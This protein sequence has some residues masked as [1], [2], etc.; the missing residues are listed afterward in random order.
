M[1][2]LLF[3]LI[4]VCEEKYVFFF[5]L[6]KEQNPGQ[7]QTSLHPCHYLL[8]NQNYI[9]NSSIGLKSTDPYLQANL[10]SP[11]AS[12]MQPHESKSF[13]HVNGLIQPALP[14]RSTDI[15]QHFPTLDSRKH[16]TRN[17]QAAPFREN[18]LLFY[19]NSQPRSV[20]QEEGGIRVRASDGC[21][22]AKQNTYF[23]NE[24]TI[25]MT[26]PAANT[27]TSELDSLN[28]DSSICSNGQH[29]FV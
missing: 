11:V 22:D 26:P 6:I 28:G 5:F 1:V 21:R 8:P 24:N 19:S 25:T 20:G 15:G 16:L 10:F 9:Q 18:H 27:L 7:G 17:C 4:L 12:P 29:E 23:V 3:E 13:P 2:I 14:F